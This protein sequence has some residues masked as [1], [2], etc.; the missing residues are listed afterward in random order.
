MWDVLSGVSK[1]GIRPVMFCPAR[2]LSINEYFFLLGTP[3]FVK[4]TLLIVKQLMYALLCSVLFS[5][6]L[7]KFLPIFYSLE[8]GSM[9]QLLKC[10]CLMS[11]T[12]A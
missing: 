1:N 4:Q 2:V 8:Q 6:V 7:D 3:F 5:H 12:L 10:I 11:S 9:P